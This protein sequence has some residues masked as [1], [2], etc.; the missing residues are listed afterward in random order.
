MKP[1]IV[2][3]LLLTVTVSCQSVDEDASVIRA[4][5]TI[6][7]ASDISN[8]IS[9]SP[10]SPSDA[11]PTT[12]S[13]LSSWYQ[14]AVSALSDWS[15]RV[16][17]F[18]KWLMTSEEYTTWDKSDRHELQL[19]SDMEERA[20]QR[21]KILMSSDGGSS[22]SSGISKS[23]TDHISDAAKAGRRFFSATNLITLG[24]ETGKDLSAITSSSN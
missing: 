24:Y 15:V 7:E 5:S 21:N 23:W 13:F 2:C 1:V 8:E 16:P 20:Q 22:S 3:L 6:V 12:P 17:S 14:S 10:A 18:M 9:D 19:S 4:N 11:T